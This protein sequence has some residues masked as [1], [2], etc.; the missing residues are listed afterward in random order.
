MPKNLALVRNAQA[1][2]EKQQSKSAARQVLII[3]Q[4]KC[5]PECMNKH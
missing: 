5:F 3:Y 4:E 1:K 2:G